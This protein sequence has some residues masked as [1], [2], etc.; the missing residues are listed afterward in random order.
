MADKIPWLEKVSREE[1]WLVGVSGGAD[2]VAL[3]YFLVVEGFTN[4]VVCHVDHGLRG[5]VSTEDAKFVKRLAGKLG[6]AFEMGKVD[7][8]LKM[9]DL[10]ESLETCARHARHD[11]FRECARTEVRLF[12]CSVSPSCG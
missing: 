12:P 10:G 7:V 4:L 8:A 9:K 1:C 11:F 3:L 2:S 6:I 5:R